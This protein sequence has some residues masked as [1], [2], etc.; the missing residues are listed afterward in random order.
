MLLKALGNK[1]IKRMELSSLKK[2]S[3]K[4]NNPH[5]GLATKT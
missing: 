3:H 5:S 4:Q 2:P 1:K